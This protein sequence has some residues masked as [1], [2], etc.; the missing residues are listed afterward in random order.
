L[1]DPKGV[2]IDADAARPSNPKLKTQL[3]GLVK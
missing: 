3:D 1:I 2:V